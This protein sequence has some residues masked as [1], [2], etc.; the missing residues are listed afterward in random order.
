MECPISI[1]EICKQLR[2]NREIL[3]MAPNF[4]SA[5]KTYLVLPSSTCEAER[6]FSTLRRLKTYLPSTITQQRLNHLTVLTTHRDETEVWLKRLNIAMKRKL[7]QATAASTWWWGPRPRLGWVESAVGLP[8]GPS[9]PGHS[10]S[11]FCY[12]AP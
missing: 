2:E 9:Y 6:S 1:T 10:T 8:K 4:I 3:D 12:A 11:F 7:H 5:L